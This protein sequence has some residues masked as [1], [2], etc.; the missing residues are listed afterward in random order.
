MVAA[1]IR[2]PS[3][4]AEIGDGRREIQVDADT[5]GGALVEL[6]VSLPQLRVHIFDETGGVRP[7]V[8][9]FYDGRAARDPESLQAD[10]AEGS[11]I[12]ILQAVSGG[13]LD[14]GSTRL[15]PKASSNRGRT[16]PGTRGSP[17]R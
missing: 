1:T 6:F 11:T 3:L 4:L 17:R 2:I 7:H 13:A 16:P 14:A 10:L 15:P 5:V 8:S 9:V 12:T